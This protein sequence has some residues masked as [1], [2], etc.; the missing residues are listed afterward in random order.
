MWLVDLVT[1]ALYWGVVATVGGHYVEW[2]HSIGNPTLE[3]LP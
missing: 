2:L 3:D 1:A